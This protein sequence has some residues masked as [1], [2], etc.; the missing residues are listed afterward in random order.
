M[1]EKPLRA[2]LSSDDFKEKNCIFSRTE[3]RRQGL[4]SDWNDRYRNQTQVTD[5]FIYTEHEVSEN[6][7]KFVHLVNKLV[8]VPIVKI[9]RDWVLFSVDFIG[10][11]ERAHFMKLS[12]HVDAAVWDGLPLD[13]R[14]DYLYPSSLGSNRSSLR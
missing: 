9:A 1:S 10:P 2:L 12:V 5:H 11:G 6:G 13:L 8:S 14:V 3:D 4:P 7:T